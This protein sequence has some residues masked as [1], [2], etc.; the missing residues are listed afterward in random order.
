MITSFYFD[1]SKLQQKKWFNNHTYRELWRMYAIVCACMF[2]HVRFNLASINLNV[3][4]KSRF[5]CLKKAKRDSL[6]HAQCRSKDTWK[7]ESITLANSN[8]TKDI[9]STHHAQFIFLI[10][11]SKGLSG[12]TFWDECANKILFSYIMIEVKRSNHRH[13]FVKNWLEWPRSRTDVEGVYGNRPALMWA[14][15]S[16]WL[17]ACSLWSTA[18]LKSQNQG[19]Y[20][21]SSRTDC[22]SCTFMCWIWWRTWFSDVQES[23]LEDNGD[24]CAEWQVVK[25][26]GFSRAHI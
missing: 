16:D 19:I 12:G 4:L 24:Q 5:P 7:N 2:L 9:T 14:A 13:C 17:M 10:T 1:L 21:Q 3:L 26:Y 8:T 25:W 23:D 15:E 22:S 20:S 18:R 6:R 11:N